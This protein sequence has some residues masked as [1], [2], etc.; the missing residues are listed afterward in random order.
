MSRTDLPVCCFATPGPDEDL[1][2]RNTRPPATP[3]DNEPLQT[4][5]ALSACGLFAGP[6]FTRSTSSAGSVPVP[7]RYPPSRGAPRARNAMY[8]R[9]NVPTKQ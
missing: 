5:P 4:G 2:K 7:R 8:S 1:G 3:P 6:A 9:M